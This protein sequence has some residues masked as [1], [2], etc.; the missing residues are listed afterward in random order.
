MGHPL[1]KCDSFKFKPISRQAEEFALGLDARERKKLAAACQSVGSSLVLGRP[2]AGRT[3]LIRSSKIRGM[4][5]LKVT[6][7]G[8]DGPQLRL[9]CVREGDVVLVARGLVKRSRC[10]SRHDIELAEK[11]IAEHR[12]RTRE[13]SKRR[14]H[15]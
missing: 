9:I 10:I 8:A 2:P 4:F 14:S 3:E 13:Q 12:E 5:E 11:T 1:Y 15:P 6:W 7:P